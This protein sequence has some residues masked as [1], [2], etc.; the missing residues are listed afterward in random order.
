MEIEYNKDIVALN[1]IDIQDIGN[2]CLECISADE[3]YFYIINKTS[4]GVCTMFTCGPIIPDVS[5]IPSG[6][7]III[8]K[9]EYNT[10]LILKE[11]SLYINN[12]NKKIVEVN[13]ISVEQA[14][15]EFRDIGKYIMDY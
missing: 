11:L 8:N 6:F 10:K 4:L 7:A 3:M 5:L 13:E 2:C 1:F 15:K 14:V 12:K 9:I